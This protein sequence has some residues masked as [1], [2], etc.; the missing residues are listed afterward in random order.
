VKIFYT[1]KIKLQVFV[2]NEFVPCV[3][4]HVLAKTLTCTVHISIESFRS[5]LCISA[6]SWPCFGFKSLLKSFRCLTWGP[7]VSTIICASTAS[8]NL[9]PQVTT[10]W[11]LRSWCT[12][13]QLFKLVRF[14]CKLKHWL[15]I[16]NVLNLYD[17][18]NLSYR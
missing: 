6:L 13:K 8:D 1:F 14:H 11:T 9:Q 3:F 18:C 4:E 2:V 16:C 17:N 7:P 15:Y 10:M 5:A 12:K